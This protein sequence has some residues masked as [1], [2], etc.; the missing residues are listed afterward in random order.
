MFF[1]TVIP[2]ADMEWKSVPGEEEQRLGALSRH[3][4]VFKEFLIMFLE[5][6]PFSFL[7]LKR[8]LCHKPQGKQ[9]A[10]QTHCRC[11]QQPLSSAQGAHTQER[12]YYGKEVA[13]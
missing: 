8:T 1:M 6:L 13:I 12:W 4:V 5:E 3:A 10:E 11:R 7:L 2:F 9:L